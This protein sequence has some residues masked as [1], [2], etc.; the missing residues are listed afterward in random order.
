[1]GWLSRARSRP[2]LGLVGYGGFG[3]EVLPYL[4]HEMFEI[5]FLETAPAAPEVHGV[6]V[7]PLSEFHS[8]DSERYFNI[9]VGAST[10]RE[11]LAT[12]L[13]NAGAQPYSIIA[14]TAAVNPTSSIGEG[15]IIC[16]FAIITADAVIGRYFHCNLYSYVAHDCVIGDL[17]TLAPKVA[18]N[19]NVHIGDHAYL[20]TGAVIR[21]GASGDPLV[22]GE[23]ATIGMGAVVTRDVP[24]HSTVVGNPARVLEGR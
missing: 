10:V 18:I 16:E 11:K 20:G 2:L 6:P 22:I 1:M 8:L 4:D 21:N 14:P 7:M 12:D 9:A 3:R 5:V 17:V 13:E 19:G 23:Y 24:P 15:A